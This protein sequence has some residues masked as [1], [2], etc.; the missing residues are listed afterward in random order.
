M[1][2]SVNLTCVEF[3]ETL[4][5]KAP[6]PG[7][8]G[9]SALLGAIGVALASM[10]ASL[11]AGKPKY[12]D[13]EA[14]IDEIIAQTKELRETLLGLVEADARAFEPLSK[15]YGMASNT[16]EEK[17]HKDKVMQQCLQ[18]ACVV[19]IEIMKACGR[20]IEV[21]ENL[22]QVGAQIAISD[23]GCAACVCQAA[24]RAAS[25]NVF[26]NTKLMSDS[27]Y[28]KAYNLEANQLLEK[29]VP[30]SERVFAEISSS[31]SGSCA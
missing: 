28:A 4:A 11:T 5:S 29:Y 17:A 27:E 6:T 26:V 24:L 15:A 25:L 9:A 22:A 18:E 20:A 12:K 14:K 16:E 2:N 23:T 13:V 31:L 19:P 21:I 3:V 10:S 7:G 1:D 8:G 30:A